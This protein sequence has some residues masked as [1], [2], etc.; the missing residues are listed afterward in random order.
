MNREQKIN[1]LLERGPDEERRLA[2]N[3]LD[4]IARK[5]NTFGS[6]E[7]RAGRDAVEKQHDDA[8]RELQALSDERLEQA[9]SEKAV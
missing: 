3:D 1:R 5:T 6:K 9:L 7:H 2:L 8:R 4:D